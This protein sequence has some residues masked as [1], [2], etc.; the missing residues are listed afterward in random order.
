M[1]GWIV[2]YLAEIFCL[3]KIDWIWLLENRP[4]NHWQNIWPNLFTTGWGLSFYIFYE[5]SQLPCDQWPPWPSS[6]GLVWS[7]LAK[8]NIPQNKGVASGEG[9]GPA[10]HRE[11]QETGHM[12]C[13]LL[14]C[15]SLV[16]PHC[17]IHC[18]T[19]HRGFQKKG[20]HT[21]FFVSIGLACT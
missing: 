8:I 14:L 7:P 20:Y 6:P 18:H 16:P 21:L 17:Y 13:D 5:A 12:C 4:E 11:C 9:E 10:N 3:Q 1:Y 15:A 2:V 19:N